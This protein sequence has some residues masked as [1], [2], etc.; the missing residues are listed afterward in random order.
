MLCWAPITTVTE[1][2]SPFIVGLAPALFDNFPRSI[3][4]C[5]LG[6]DGYIRDSVGNVVENAQFWRK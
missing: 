5:S 3:G 1:A 6:E 2:D 4:G